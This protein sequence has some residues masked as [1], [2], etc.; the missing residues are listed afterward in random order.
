MK[1]IALLRGINV[2]GNSMIKMSELKNNV[3]KCGFKNVQTCINS[4]NVIFESEQE[5]RKKIEIC[6]LIFF[7]YSGSRKHL[8]G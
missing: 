2:G 7:K 3:E 5:D 4:G 6:C 8:F 1:Y